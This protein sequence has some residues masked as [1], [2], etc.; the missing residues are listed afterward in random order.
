MY[1]NTYKT[2]NKNLAFF[3]VVGLNNQ[4]MAFSC[5]FSLIDNKREEGFN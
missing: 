1:D 2:N 3:Q 5:G 4:G